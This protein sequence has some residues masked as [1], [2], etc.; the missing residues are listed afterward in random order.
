MS[1]LF[2]WLQGGK[3]AAFFAAIGAAALLVWHALATARREGAAQ[4]KA[5]EAEQYAK[6]VDRAA[7][8]A[9]ARDDVLA[10]RVQPN[11]KD[12]NRRD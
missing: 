3:I 1:W 5:K 4:Q 9:R 2:N 6:D 12:P 10:G 8:A 11:D 7:R